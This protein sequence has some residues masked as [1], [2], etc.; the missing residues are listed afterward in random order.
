MGPRKQSRGQDQGTE[1]GDA[2]GRDRGDRESGSGWSRQGEGDREED[3]NI[4]GV[5]WRRGTGG[6]RQRMQDVG[7]LQVGGRECGLDMG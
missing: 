1:G 3:E 7:F 5:V 4:R 2:M 6:L